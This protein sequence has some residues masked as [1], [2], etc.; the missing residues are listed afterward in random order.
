M[1]FKP[2]CLP[3]SAWPKAHRKAWETALVSKDILDTANPSVEWRPASVTR[4]AKAYGIWLAWNQS[5]GIEISESLPQELVKQSAVS[6]F[7]ADLQSVNA[8]VTV[9]DRVQALY[10][11]MRI[12]APPC[13]GFDWDWLRHGMRRLCARATPTRNKLIRLKSITDIEALGLQLMAD[14]DKAAQTGGTTIIE[15]ALRYRDGLM[16]ALLIHRPLRLSNFAALAL[17]TTLLMLERTALIAIPT[18]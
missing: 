12:L 6:A 11:V 13:R 17:G 5:I 10:S 16:I 7:V 15:R 9:C 14:A 18:N 3:L 4:N 8:S 1:R 2:S